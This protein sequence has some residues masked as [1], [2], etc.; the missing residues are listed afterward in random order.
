MHPAKIILRRSDWGVDWLGQVL[1]PSYR[2][3][4]VCTKRRM[5]RKIQK[6]VSDSKYEQQKSTL[7]SYWGLIKPVA[8]RELSRQIRQVVAFYR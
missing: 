1:L 2:I 4:R 7:A 6:A 5:M 3:L 8:H